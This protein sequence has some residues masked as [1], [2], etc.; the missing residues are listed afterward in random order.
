MLCKNIYSDN[1]MDHKTLNNKDV[2]IM[3]NALNEYIHCP[4]N[5]LSIGCLSNEDCDTLCKLIG[6]EA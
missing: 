1:F 6:Y 3:T 4:C 2:K 5:T